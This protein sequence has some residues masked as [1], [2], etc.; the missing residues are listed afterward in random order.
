[1]PDQK[2]FQGEIKID[3]E[4]CKGCKICVNFCPNGAIGISE[5][6]NKKGVYPVQIKDK[7]KCTGCG[8]CFL[9]CPDVAIEIYNEP[10]K[11]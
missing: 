10:R 7:G 5:K 1:M 4:K 2:K 6:I 11:K 8:I 3:E 9:V